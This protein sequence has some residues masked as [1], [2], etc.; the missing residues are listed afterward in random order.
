M[1]RQNRPKTIKIAYF[2]DLMDFLIDA[3]FGDVDFANVFLLTHQTFSPSKLVLDI[4]LRS[5]EANLGND[6][7]AH[8]FR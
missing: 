1:E 6:G 5:M 8:I 3:D 7:K 4:L 2:L